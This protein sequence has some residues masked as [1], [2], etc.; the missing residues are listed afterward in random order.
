M[1]Y[2]SATIKDVAKM[3][4]VS[5]STV[6]RVINDSKPVSPDARKRV[7][8]AVDELNYKPNQIARSL[9][10]QKSNIIGVIVEDVGLSFVSQVLRG[11]EEIA[12][13]YEYDIIV[14]STY[15]DPQMEDHYIR[16][17]L[18]KQVEGIV[19]ISESN[20]ENRKKMEETIRVPVM[21]LNRFYRNE[22][23]PTVTISN[24]RST[25]ELT[26]YL[27][28]KGHEKI[29]YIGSDIETDISVEKYKKSGYKRAM[30][31]SNLE[32]NILKYGDKSP[33]SAEDNVK[34]IIE[35]IQNDELTAIICNTYELA[36]ELMNMLLDADIRVPD[37]VSVVGIG[38]GVMAETY[39]P[40]LTTISEP[41]YDY[42]AVS[43]R[44]I[45]KAIQKEALM[46]KDRI[47]LPSRL[48]ER[49]SVKDIR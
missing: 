30:E 1:K 25:K 37:D 46:P 33:A 47:I 6:S 22:G 45:I 15:G 18:Q 34:T 26:K 43:I 32:E 39:R 42:G 24:E 20:N 31:E 19:V 28:D 40:R 11:V 29:L 38:D 12:R 17:L 21:Y 4:G 8:D 14:S 35:K 13:M 44:A 27:I 3:A 9:V 2:L 36:I 48:I 10:T 7:L 49:E 41:L 23:V 5:I 16:L